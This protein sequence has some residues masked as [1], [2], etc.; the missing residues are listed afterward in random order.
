MTITESPD[1]A[2]AAE[3]A[4]T[5][6]G[7]K[8]KKDKGKKDKGGKSNLVP[9]I[10]LAVGIAAGG[11]FMGG[12]GSDAAPVATTA[13]PDVVEGPL[14]GV[15]PMTVNLAGGRYLRLG[16]SIQL[17][18]AYED[19]V[20][21]EEGETFPHHDASRVQ[22]LLISTLGGR[23]GGGLSTADGRDEVKEELR[24]HLNEVFDG[25]VMEVY[26]TEFVIQ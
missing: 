16:V 3:A 5:E 1:V 7:T 10:V 26:F 12:S 4:P 25:A 2:V 6:K 22:D 20:E 19:A 24:A 18:D 23:D 21:G 13:A 8:A 11:Y 15:E 14:L 17:S 9:A